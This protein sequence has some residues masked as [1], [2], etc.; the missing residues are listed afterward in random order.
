MKPTSPTSTELYS[1]PESGSHRA[2]P[3]SGYLMA[4]SSRKMLQSPMSMSDKVGV[5]PVLS[6]IR[7]GDQRTRAE[8][9]TLGC[10]ARQ[11]GTFDDDYPL[12]PPSYCARTS[13][14]FLP[15]KLVLFLLS[16]N[17]MSGSCRRQNTTSHSSSL[18]AATV[19]SDFQPAQLV[20][21]TRCCSSASVRSIVLH[22]M[23]AMGGRLIRLVLY[24][25]LCCPA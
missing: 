5:L 8:A 11:A 6:V 12:L 16:S 1:P 10:P 14:S 20:I 19:V 2:Y 25:V 13:S 24:P 21:G 4:S 9:T 7:S 15:P 22:P 3:R 18:W 17:F 23:I